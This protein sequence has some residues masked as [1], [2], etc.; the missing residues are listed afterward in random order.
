MGLLYWTALVVVQYGGLALPVGI[1]GHG[2]PLPRLLRLPRSLR[3]GGGAPR[4]TRSGRPGSW[5]RPSSGRGLELRPRPHLLLVPLVLLGY[6]QQALLPFAQVASIDGVYGVSFLVWLGL[7]PAGAR[8]G[9]AAARGRGARRSLSVALLVGAAWGWGSWQMGRPVAET[10]KVTVGLV[11]GGVR[12]EDKWVPGV[13]LGAT[14]AATSQ[15]TEEAA[16]AGARLVV[17][18]E[19]AVPFLFDEDEA[20]AALLRGVARRRRIYLFFGNDDRE[21]LPGGEPDLRGGEA[22]RP[23]GRARRPL[24]QDPPR[25]LRRVRAAAAALHPRRALRGQ[26]RPGGLGLH[27]RATRR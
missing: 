20:L 3:L 18:P 5:A 10:G 25:S 24:P 15:L 22:P 27:A 26:A 23:V 17:W 19:S 8:R 21:R 2:R 12:Q 1:A 4:R 7:G 9:R 13:R 16:D 6:S 14:S 11:Q